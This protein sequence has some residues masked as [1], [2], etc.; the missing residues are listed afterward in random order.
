MSWNED[1]QKQEAKI[2][3]LLEIEIDCCRLQVMGTRGLDSNVLDDTG[4]SLHSF[5]CSTVLMGAYQCRLTFTYV[6]I[7]TRRSAENRAFNASLSIVI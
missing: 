2:A 4:L 7:R 1:G 5:C 6:H 3:A